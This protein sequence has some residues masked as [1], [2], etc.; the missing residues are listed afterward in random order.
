MMVERTNAER[1]H[2]YIARLK[3]LAAAEARVQEM[4]W[5]NATEADKNNAF[6]LFTSWKSAFEPSR[7]TRQRRIAG[8]CSRVARCATLPR[9]AR[10]I[11]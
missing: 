4:G 5:H 10:R 6:K 8:S 1:Q 2:C 11:G 7:V 9:E 3:A